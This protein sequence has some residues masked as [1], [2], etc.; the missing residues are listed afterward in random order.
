MNEKTANSG[1]N[2]IDAEALDGETRHAAI[3]WARRRGAHGGSMRDPVTYR[4]RGVEWVRPTDLAARGSARVAGAGINFQ[5]ELRRRTH[6]AT[7]ARV[8]GIGEHTRRLPPLSAF[9]R[10][11]ARSGTGRDAIVPA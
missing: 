7:L 9:G 2:Y 10:G 8:R 6:E 1:K 5:S 3:E 11:A 4:G